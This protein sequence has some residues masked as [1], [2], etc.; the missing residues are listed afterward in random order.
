[1]ILA[2]RGARETGSGVAAVTDAGEA[3][4]SRRRARLITAE[5]FLVAALTTLIA[6]VASK[7]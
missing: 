2:A 7:G 1:M 3:V 6:F 5:S 4:A